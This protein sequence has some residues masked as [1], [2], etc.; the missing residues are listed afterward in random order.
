MFGTH[1]TQIMRRPLALARQR[2]YKTFPL[3]F[4]GEDI[5]YTKVYTQRQHMDGDLDREE[6][7]KKLEHRS[8]RYPA[9]G[10]FNNLNDLILSTNNK[11]EV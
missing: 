5:S 4:S 6:I 7:K 10:K 2:H 1:V 8:T 9:Y 11:G 3:T